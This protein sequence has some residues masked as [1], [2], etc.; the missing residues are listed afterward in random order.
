M[1]LVGVLSLMENV[2]VQIVHTV[3]LDYGGQG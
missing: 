1:P 3:V 2:P